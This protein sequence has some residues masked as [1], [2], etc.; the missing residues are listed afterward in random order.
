MT[1]FLL[2]KM[3]QYDFILFIIRLLVGGIAILAIL[4]FV[5]RPM[6]KVFAQKSSYI[7]PHRFIRASVIGF[8]LRSKVRAGFS[9]SA[10]SCLYNR[11]IQYDFGIH[12]IE[13][14]FKLLKAVLPD[15]LNNK[16]PVRPELFPSDND[17]MKAKEL[18]K[19]RFDSERF[20]AIAPG[21]VWQTKRWPVQHFKQL[22]DLLNTNSIGTILI[23]GKDD[24]E[25][26]E[27]LTS[28][29]VLNLAGEL[30]FLESTAAIGLTKVI[31][32][33]D[34]AP[35]HMASAMNIPTIAIFGSTTSYL[36]FGP[37]ADNSFVLEKSDLECR[38]CGRHGGNKC[39]KKH[40]DCM[41]KIS[42]D[43][44]F[45]MISKIL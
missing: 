28:G 26:C 27:K 8:L 33:N 29:K 20:V 42:P 9:S 18:I 1:S 43:S 10:L 41:N 14:N 39:K 3:E 19:N 45:D 12:E 30:S 25:L 32:T 35:L 34:S 38:P 4:V 6:T 5:I 22:I 11:T 44:V 7:S 23:G 36:G 13:R 31:V 17:L 21:S 24:R 16:N 15:K 40:F 2:R 37:L